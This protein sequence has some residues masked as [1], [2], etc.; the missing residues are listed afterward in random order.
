MPT[1]EDF[2]VQEWAELPEPVRQRI[3]QGQS[4]SAINDEGSDA[5]LWDLDDEE[6]L[7]LSQEHMDDLRLQVATPPEMTFR[8]VG[9]KFDSSGI[10]SAVLLDQTGQVFLAGTGL[11]EW[12]L[13]PVDN[14]RGMEA[15]DLLA[16]RQGFFVIPPDREVCVTS[17]DHDSVYDAWHAS[18]PEKDG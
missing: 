13:E 17:V 9:L 14:A 2:S 4:V 16:F 5:N 7:R 1:R 18:Q 12:E 15:A 11:E 10:Y 3:E 8:V 6:E